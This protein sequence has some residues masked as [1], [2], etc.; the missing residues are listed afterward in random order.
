M[1]RY[2]RQH[3]LSGDHDGR[4][5]FRQPGINIRVGADDLF[6]TQVEAPGD[7]G[8]RVVFVDGDH[9]KRADHIIASGVETELMTGHRNGQRFNRRSSLNRWLSQKRLAAA[10]QEKSGAEAAYETVA[11]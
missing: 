4:A 3:E 7:I 2:I 11:E 6:V 5:C 10:Q 1:A 9:L 8:K